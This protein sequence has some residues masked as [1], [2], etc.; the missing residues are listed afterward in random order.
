[1]APVGESWMNPPGVGNEAESTICLLVEQ[2]LS[3][4]QEGLRGKQ[5]AMKRLQCQREESIAPRTGQL[6]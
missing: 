6:S 1:M 4:E 5:K 2:G 3:T